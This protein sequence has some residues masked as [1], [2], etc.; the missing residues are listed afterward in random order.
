MTDPS[1]SELYEKLGRMESKFDEKLSNILA[2]VQKT[3]GR[4]TRLEKWK[5]KLDVIADYRKENGNGDRPIDWQKL[6]MYS[7]G[8]VATALAV[9]SVLAGK[10]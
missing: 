6:M 4:V 7:L 9:I 2:Q 5:D 3:N 10:R 8:L 1:N